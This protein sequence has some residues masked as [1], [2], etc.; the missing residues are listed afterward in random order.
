M[1]QPKAAQAVRP[2]LMELRSPPIKIAPEG[3][4]CTT[5]INEPSTHPTWIKSCT[6]QQTNS[7]C[8]LIYNSSCLVMLIKKQACPTLELITNHQVGSVS[9][10]TPSNEPNPLCQHDI[11]DIEIQHVVAINSPAPIAS[12]MATESLRIHFL[13]N[14]S[15]SSLINGISC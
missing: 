9:A 3:R 8:I 7:L 1:V 12:I 2:Q 4:G 14:F 10:N 15:L 5:R 6:K 11:W 13:T